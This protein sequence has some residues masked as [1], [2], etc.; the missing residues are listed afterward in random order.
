MTVRTTTSRRRGPARH[1]PVESASPQAQTGRH[2]TARQAWEGRLTPEQR[3][4]VRA[5]VGLVAVHLRRFVAGLETPR[6]DREWDDLFQEG[7]LGL[8]QAAVRFDPG[9]GIPFAAYA[10]PRIHQAVSHAL[11]TRFSLVRLPARSKRAAAV[12]GAGPAAGRSQAATPSVIA[13]GDE[14]ATRL[15][16]PRAERGRAPTGETVGDRLHAKYVRAVGRASAALADSPSSRQDRSALIA[17]LVEHRLRVADP[18]Q[19]RALRQIARDTGS[20]YA[21]V[22]QCEKQLRAAVEAQLAGDP[23]FV[24]LRDWARHEPAGGRLPLDGRREAELAAC[25]TDAWLARWRGRDEPGRAQML[26]QLLEVSGYGTN[27]LARACLAR[28]TPEQREMLLAD[29]VS[30]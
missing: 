4:L 19:R 1:D 10:L 3:E 26:L 8:M 5:N 13:L 6:R 12:E 28:L 21:R 23:E 2:G 17:V 27:Q 22:A 30:R 24:A 16:D 15:A 9:R 20:S 11:R 14:A 25:G 29:G 18:E 7:C